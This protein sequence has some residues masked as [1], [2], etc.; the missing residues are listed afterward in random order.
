MVNFWN[1]DPHASL[2]HL[3]FCPKKTSG[4]FVQIDS[5]FSRVV[6]TSHLAL[7]TMSSPRTP[8]RTLALAAVAF[9]QLLCF[10]GT[11][12]AHPWN[13]RDSADSN[14]ASQSFDY[15]IVGTGP[16]GSTLARRLTEDANVTVAVIEAGTWPQDLVGNLT[17]VPGYNLVF[18]Q[19]DITKPAYPVDWGYITTPQAGLQ[20]AQVRYQRGKCL[21]GG[22]NLNAMAWGFA[23]MGTFDVW[24]DL[25]GDKSW[26]W[27]TV[28]Q[29]Y[30][31]SMNFAPVTAGRRANATVEFRQQDAVTGGPVEVRYPSYAYSW[32]TWLAA[33]LNQVGVPTTDTFIDG[34]LNGSAWQA[35][36]LNHT[37]GTRVSASTAYLSPSLSR[38]NLHLFQETLAEKILFHR[39]KTAR[40]VLVRSNSTGKH[41]TIKARREVIVSGGVFN[42]PQLLM[43]SGVGP[44]AELEKHNITVIADRPGVGQNMQDQF[45]FGISYQIQTPIP[46]TKGG[47]PEAVAYAAEFDKNGTGPLGN[48][49]GEYTGYEKLPAN[50]R[51]SFSA[52]TNNTLAKYPADWPEMEF[53]TLPAF[54]G[55]GRTTGP[56][57]TN[58]S[59]ATIL[60]AIQTPT[61]LGNVT[62]N[63]SSALDAPLINPNWLTTTEDIEVSVA[64]FKRIREVWTAPVMGNVTIGEEF[65]PG[66]SVQTD[67]Q[68]ADFVRGNTMPLYH[69]SSTCKMGTANDTQAVVDS[70]GRVFGVNKLRVV[71]I[72]AL[73]FVPPGTAPQSAVYMVAEKLA[74]VIKKD[75]ARC[76]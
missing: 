66:A 45:F 49:G 57:P 73:P 2:D 67:E 46:V 60:A 24:A 68:I 63:S 23:S 19:P 9:T 40:G 15:V 43:L 25:V 1:L 65:F 51:G 28:F 58:G 5:T 4:T 71:D 20:G 34:Y 53:I 76:D 10:S 18:D 29:Y 11:S 74:D 33:A 42:S 37:D 27:D 36:C 32:T 75:N 14:V 39:N 31:K 59:Y 48:G 12:T 22:S 8:V 13:I 30:R 47:S 72:S 21:G 16:G 44:K 64:M 54:I 41:Y 52:V 17:T 7:S 50:L 35:N 61:S 6:V 3:D 62:L 70:H 38:N 69:A 56:A 55:N 26:L